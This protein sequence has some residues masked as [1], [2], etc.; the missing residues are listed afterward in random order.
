MKLAQSYTTKSE[1]LSSQGEAYI[2]AR[3]EWWIHNSVYNLN[4]K[5]KDVIFHACKCFS[6]HL[7]QHWC[8]EVSVSTSL[9]WALHKQVKTTIG[10]SEIV[11]KIVHRNITLQQNISKHIFSSRMTLTAKMK[12]KTKPMINLIIGIQDWDIGKPKCFQFG[13]NLWYEQGSLFP[14]V[15]LSVLNMRLSFVTQEVSVSLVCMYVHACCVCIL[16]LQ[17]AHK[18]KTLVFL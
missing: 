18:S 4:I 8:S 12:R 2:G 15:H 10:G 9:R 6:L 1:Y 13:P 11:G 14:A 16:T 5:S 3:N 17:H 7:Q